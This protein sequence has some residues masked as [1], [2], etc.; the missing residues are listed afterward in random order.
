MIDWMKRRIKRSRAR[1][2]KTLVAPHRQAATRRE[3]ATK[4]EHETATP[5]RNASRPARNK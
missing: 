2:H 4:P 3:A 1:C 5:A